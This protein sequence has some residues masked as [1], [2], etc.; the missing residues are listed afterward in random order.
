MTNI[1]ILSRVAVKRSTGHRQR[2]A[3]ATKQQV[4][5]VARALFAE[6]GYV[7]TTIS[8]I[9][10]EADIPVQTIYSPSDRRPGSSTRSPSSG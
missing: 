10:T 7:A 8:T 3:E 1:V 6:H 9:A 2:Q 5:Q 4:A